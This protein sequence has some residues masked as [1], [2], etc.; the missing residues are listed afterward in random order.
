ME[1]K[2]FMGC[3]LAIGTLFL[4]SSCSATPAE[5]PVVDLDNPSGFVDIRISD[6]LDN[7]TLVPLET[8][9][10]MLLSTNGMIY[11]VTNNYIIVR[12]NEKLLQLDRQGKYLRTLAYRGN[13]PNEFNMIVGTYIDEKRELLYYRDSRSAESY[14]CINLK[15]GAFVEFSKPEV[16][17]FNLTLMD[18][19]G[20]MYGFLGRNTL[21]MMDNEEPKASDTLLF[22]YNPVEKRI[23][24][25]T[26]H[27]R[28]VHNNSSRI[29]TMQGGEIF[30]LCTPYS[31][32][33]FKIDG[34]KII[35]RFVFKLKD[36]VTDIQQGGMLTSIPFSCTLGMV[37]RNS[38]SNL[39][40]SQSGGTINSITV[41]NQSQTYLLL[42]RK[43]ALQTIR[44]ITVDPIAVT[45]DV[46][47]YLKLSNEQR[48][49][50]FKIGF[51]P[52]VSGVW[53]HYAVE[54]IDMVDMI[55]QALKGDQI[56]PVQR[57][58]LEEVA[59]KIDYDSNPVLMIGKIK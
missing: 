1:F 13:G 3:V 30:F 4:L 25:F 26:G 11:T 52:T 42:N 20:N 51:L 35:P 16:S 36:Q 9:D 32:T 5:C 33:L 14:P 23:D 48:R 49:E 56:T 31:D 37:V 19:E 46:D 45:I 22:R 12:T 53:G 40:V 24:F 29:I 21:R 57:K 39:T 44:S 38:R 2:H 34:T 17:P 50:K 6:M 18:T 10:D 47:E 58:A 54:A 43:G 27:H 28:F 15:T 55:E 59:K 7:I 8:S 41:A